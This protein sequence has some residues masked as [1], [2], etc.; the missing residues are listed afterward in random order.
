M[1][2]LALPQRRFIAGH[3]LKTIM[4]S[5]IAHLLVSSGQTLYKIQKIKQKIVAGI[6]ILGLMTNRL[7]SYEEFIQTIAY[8]V[9]L[10]LL[11]RP[12]TLLK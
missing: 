7:F 12:T 11:Y 3:F 6:E 1:I 10:K 4:N 2:K 9:F 5:E 8:G